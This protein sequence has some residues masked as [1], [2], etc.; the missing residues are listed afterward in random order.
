MIFLAFPRKNVTAALIFIKKVVG[1]SFQFWNSSLGIVPIYEGKYLPLI[2]LP[3][4]IEQ[5]YL[6]SDLE[7]LKCLTYFSP[8][9]Y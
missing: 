6:G 9:F 5:S 1:K 2:D 8:L 7:T 3:L 4:P